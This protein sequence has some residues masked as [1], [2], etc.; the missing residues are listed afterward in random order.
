MKVHYFLQ[1]TWKGLDMKSYWV[2]FKKNLSN[3]FKKL[4]VQYLFPSSRYILQSFPRPWPFPL[5]MMRILI[6]QLSRRNFSPVVIFLISKAEKRYLSKP[7]V[8]F[9]W[10]FHSCFWPNALLNIFLAKR[11]KRP[12]L[13]RKRRRRAI[14]RK[15]GPFWYFRRKFLLRRRPQQR[16]K[17]LFFSFSAI[18]GNY[19][20]WL[21]VGRTQKERGA[22]FFCG[23]SG[24]DERRSFETSCQ[25]FECFLLYFS[26]N[27]NRKNQHVFLVLTLLYNTIDLVLVFPSPLCSLTFTLPSPPPFS[28]EKPWSL[29]SRSFPSHPSNLVPLPLS[30][31]ET[32]R[33]LI[34]CHSEREKGGAIDTACSYRMG[35]KVTSS[36]SNHCL[37][38]EKY[39][40]C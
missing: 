28:W 40:Y 25:V 31:G 36:I 3:S 26:I 33:V 7:C 19:S 12:F 23:V 5:F 9:G 32:P 4:N 38:G 20:E 13:K 39:F 14:F 15:K 6:Q 2:F 27:N 16:H 11:L 17:K 24:R 35:R 37:K 21:G 18:P 1:S 10:L 22:L 34:M 29:L 30:G 8:I